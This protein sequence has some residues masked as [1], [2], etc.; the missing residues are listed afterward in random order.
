MESDIAGYTLYYGTASRNYSFSTNTGN[1]TNFTIDLPKGETYFFAVTAYNNLALESDFSPEI[2]YSLPLSNSPPVLLVPTTIAASQNSATPVTGLHVS[3]TDANSGLVR[4][5]LSVASGTLKVAA[6]VTGGVSASQISYN[7]SSFVEVIAPLAALNKTLG[8][9]NG[10]IYTG[11][12]DMIGTDSLLVEVTDNGTM[13]SGGA[14]MDFK[15]VPIVITGTS[16]PNTETNQPPSNLPGAARILAPAGGQSYCRL[17]LEFSWQDATNGGDASWFRICILDTNGTKCVD[18]WTQNK[19]LQLAQ[20]LNPGHYI[21]WVQSWN[22]AGLGP[23]S[24]ADFNVQACPP[25]APKPYA[26]QG[27][28]L[29]SPRVNY[30]WSVENASWYQLYVYK[31]GA[32][33][34]NKW[35]SIPNYASLRAC[36]ALVSGHKPGKYNWWVRG[37]NPDGCGPWSGTGEF[38]VDYDAPAAITLF[39][40]TGTVYSPAAIDFAW[41]DDITADWYC[42]RVDRDGTNYYYKWLQSTN[43]TF[44]NHLPAGDYSWSVQ[45]WNSQGLG[46]LSNSL[47]FTMIT[48]GTPLSPVDSVTFTGDPCYRWYGDGSSTWYQIYINKDGAF[49]LYQWVSASSLNNDNGT[50]E[51][52]GI[53]GH[54]AGDFVWWLRGWSPDTGFGPW[55]SAKRFSLTP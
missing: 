17:S 45:G 8:A 31:D 20:A 25:N 39:S 2:S 36:E 34:L 12:V 4:L 24:G 38:I 13:D 10:L 46:T 23:W 35:V 50:L 11:D 27:D 43:Y 6:N 48:D 5:R 22:A 54:S 26:P 44:T 37:W 49:F 47:H 3:D 16:V 32:L 55:S 33:Y 18:T 21:W 1:V 51:Y 19:T 29:A 52:C 9:A 42:L 53:Q 28:S 30:S 41:S 7:N 40:P 14:E 15:S